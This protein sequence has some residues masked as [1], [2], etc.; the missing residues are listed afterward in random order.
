M[1]N[2]S[3]GNSTS[4]FNAAVGSS[5]RSR[6]VDVSEMLDP[7]EGDPFSLSAPTVLGFDPTKG[8]SGLMNDPSE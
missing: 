1:T 6:R 5:S 3:E 7:D 4:P 2:A 8:D